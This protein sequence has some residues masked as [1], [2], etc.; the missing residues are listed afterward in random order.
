MAMFDK[1]VI[2][3]NAP[4]QIRDVLCQSI[5]QSISHAVS[6]SGKQ[7]FGQKLI[8]WYRKDTR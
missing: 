5:N 6:Q 3:H 8:R 1:Y 7:T 2:N 4:G